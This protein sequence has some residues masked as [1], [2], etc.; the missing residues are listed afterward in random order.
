MRKITPYRLD[1]AGYDALGAA[2]TFADRKVELLNGLLVMMTT[3]PAH[4]NAVTA[5]GDLLR[6]RLP[7]SDWTVREEKPLILSRHWKP[8]P[9]LVVVRGPRSRY[10]RRT[11]DH[12][13]VALVVEIS[14]TTYAKDSGPK[15]RAYARSGIGDYWIVDL[16]RRVTEVYQGGPQGLLLR[17]TITEHETLPLRLDDVDFAPIPTAELFP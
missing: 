9:D 2:G 5:L 11:P 6:E 10:A 7:K 4:D 16:G 12:R 15:R 17:T 13:N 14:D 1:V 3:G 8:I